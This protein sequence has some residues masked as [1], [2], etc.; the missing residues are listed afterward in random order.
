MGRLRRRRPALP[1]LRRLQPATGLG[2]SAT[3]GQQGVVRSAEW[4]RL[5]LLA[6]LVIVAVGIGTTSPA[7]PLATPAMTPQAFRT[8]PP[9]SPTPIAGLHDYAVPV[10][11]PQLVSQDPVPAPSPPRRPTKQRATGQAP[12]HIRVRRVDDGIIGPARWHATGRDGYY[13]AAGCRLRRAIGPDWRGQV[14]IVNYRRRI[15]TVRLNDAIA[16]CTRT[17]IDLSDEAF[18]ALAPL[19]RGVLRVGVGW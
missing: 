12:R 2:C 19:S 6:I 16:R 10:E 14:V 17:V 5:A 11:G 13:A 4:T 15:V 9:P 7:V 18:R 3:A 8:F 1:G